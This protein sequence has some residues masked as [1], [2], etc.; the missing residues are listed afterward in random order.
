MGLFKNHLDLSDYV[1]RCIILAKRIL[2][3][4]LSV[5]VSLSVFEFKLG[6]KYLFIQ[7]F[8]QKCV[9]WQQRKMEPRQPYLGLRDQESLWWAWDESVNRAVSLEG[10][11]LSENRWLQFICLISV[12]QDNFFSLLG[13]LQ[14]FFGWD[15]G[16]FWYF[17]TNPGSKIGAKFSL[18]GHLLNV[19][20]N[21]FWLRSCSLFSLYR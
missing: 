19:T 17:F 12:G 9:D 4:S 5:F 16:L 20:L 7:M 15:L 8:D 21:L 2:N 13:A 11:R 14:A 1:K 3:F 18:N 10:L 6:S